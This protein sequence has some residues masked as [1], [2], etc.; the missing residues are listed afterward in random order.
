MPKGILREVTIRHT[1]LAW[2]ISSKMLSYILN[3]ELDSCSLKMLF[4]VHSGSSENR[5]TV[6][7]SRKSKQGTLVL[8]LG[9]CHKHS[10]EYTQSYF[11]LLFLVLF[12]LSFSL[13]VL[14]F[15]KIKMGDN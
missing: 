10:A 13:H 14:F 9:F 3:E 5:Q 12:F 15:I 11:V 1:H 4:P 2:V 7:V 8:F 6:S